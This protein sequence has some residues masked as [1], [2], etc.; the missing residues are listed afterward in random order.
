MMRKVLPDGLN[1]WPLQHVLDEVVAAT[2][3]N[4]AE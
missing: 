1:V 4:I 2:D 3:Q